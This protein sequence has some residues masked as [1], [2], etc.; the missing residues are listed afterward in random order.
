MDPDASR[1]TLGWVSEPRDDLHDGDRR[2]KTGVI[3]FYVACTMVGVAAAVAAMAWIVFPDSPGMLTV[4][5]VAAV[6]TIVSG[7]ASWYYLAV[8]RRER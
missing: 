5:S 4:G 1:A 2:F 6:L 3:G 7:V 8:S